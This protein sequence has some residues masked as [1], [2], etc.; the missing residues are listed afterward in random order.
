[1]AI[2][3]LFYQPA[4]KDR[5]HVIFQS[6]GADLLRG[7]MPAFDAAYGMQHNE[8][9]CGGVYLLDL[10]IADAVLDDGGKTFTVNAALVL[11]IGQVR[12]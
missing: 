5:D 2:L 9:G 8:Y 6:F 1:M 7:A 12:I 4:Y 10:F 3:S 11:E